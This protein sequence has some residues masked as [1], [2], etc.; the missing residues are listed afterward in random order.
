M[1]N[2]KIRKATI[3]DLKSIQ[4]LNL[5]LFKKEIVDFDN[6]LD[7][8]WPFSEIGRKNFK[9]AIIKDNRIVFI[10]EIDSNVIGYIAGRIS[11]VPDYRKAKKMSEANNM[12]VSKKY[13]S[14]GIG[15]QLMR[16]FLEWS[17]KKGVKRVHL[18]ASAE[19]KK[20]IKF[21]KKFDFEEYDLVLEKNI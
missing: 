15:T 1:K 4:N 16:K 13:R 21:Y 8:N 5:M 6:T 10:A 9:E 17:K 20:A 7:V 2:L 11:S 3:A 18:V 19:N 12:F 14:G